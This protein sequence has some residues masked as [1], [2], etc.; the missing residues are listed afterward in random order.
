MP[1][2]DF[3]DIIFER[4]SKEYGAYLLRKSYNRVV[5]KS[6]VMACIF[7]TLVVLIPFLRKPEQKTNNIYNSVY[8]TM[9]N[10]GAPDEQAGAPPP[11]EPPPPAPSGPSTD[12]VSVIHSAENDI[13]AVPEVVD[14]VMLSENTLGLSKDSL[15][16]VS[17]IEG[18]N[19][20]S[21]DASG[22]L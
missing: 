22:V 2:P 4:R 13:Y 19:N 17:N 1:I 20:G 8:L 11:G 7:G 14:T 16:G 3:N 10:L 15:P 12:Q 9:E 5:I 21:A 6:I 18:T